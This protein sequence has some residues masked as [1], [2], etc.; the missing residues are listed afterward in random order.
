M[1]IKPYISRIVAKSALYYPFCRILAVNMAFFSQNVAA[2][3][4]SGNH[5]VLAI[6]NFM[7]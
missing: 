3:H 2:G 7:L 4:W 1:M 6:P 5:I